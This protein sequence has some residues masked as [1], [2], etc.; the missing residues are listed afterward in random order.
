MLIVG[1]S[2]AA[3][4]VGNIAATYPEIFL[5][6]PFLYTSFGAAYV[7]RTVRI[8]RIATYLNNY[9]R[10]ALI[11]ILGTLQVQ[12]WEVYKKY[13]V[14]RVKKRAEKKN[15]VLKRIPELPKVLDL[16]RVG[17]FVVPSMFS[18]A[19]FI[20]FY[21]KPWNIYIEA[22]FALTIIVAL[23][24]VYLFAKSEDTSG[25]MLDMDSKSMIAWE[26]AIRSKTKQANKI[27]D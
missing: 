15:F 25:I 9:L 5:L 16:G 19:L 18:I 6:F 2:F 8:L 13:R 3:L 21:N 4:F 7:D 12:Q 23:L 22:L 11:E 20:F 10:E 1:G 14:Y 26:A 27:G 17:H 24:P